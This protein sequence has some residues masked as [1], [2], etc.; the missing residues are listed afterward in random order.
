MSKNGRYKAND[1]DIL[2]AVCLQGM[3]MWVPPGV[4]QWFEDDGKH[5]C[6]LLD[7]EEEELYQD[8]IREARADWAYKQA[9]A[10]IERS[11]Q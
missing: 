5:G 3:G 8:R 2:A 10:M 9:D 4:S 1:R 7:V 6:V 11:K